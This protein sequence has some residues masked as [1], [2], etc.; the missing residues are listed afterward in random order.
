L[1]EV[2]AHEQKSLVDQVVASLGVGDTAAALNA[3]DQESKAPHPRST[4]RTLSD[5]IYDPIR[6]SPR[7]AAFVRSLGFNPA[8]LATGKGGRP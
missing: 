7:F 4:G 8:V 2:R 1:K 5:P 3:L 6:S